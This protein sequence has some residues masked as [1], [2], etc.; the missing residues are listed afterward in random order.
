MARKIIIDT[1]PGIDDA[2]AIF[3]ALAAPE[4]E[5]LGLTTVF[6]NG[7]TQMSTANALHLLEIAGRTDIPVAHGAE[8]PMGMA[9]QGG[10][11]QVHGADAQGNLFLPAPAGKPVSMHAA[12]FIIDQVMAAPGEI[13]LV[14]LAPLTNIALAF[15]LK[16]DLPQYIREIVLMGGAAFVPGNITPAAEANIWNDPEAADIVFGADCNI[17]MIG[18]DVT[19]HLFLPGSRLEQFASLGNPRA[20]HLARILPCYRDFHVR[21]LGLDGIHVHDSSTISY[22]LRPDLFTL[23]GHPVRV[24]LTGLGRGKTWPAVGRSDVESAWAGRRP[25]QIAVKVDAD[26]ALALEWE[27]HSRTLGR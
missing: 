1:D 10:A 18:L 12:Q 4:L 22:L 21:Q 26:A 2:L 11:P 20:D 3:Y 13:T 14:P 24:E 9:F 16:P 5:I 27:H 7:S 17:V 19:E 23:E 6:G 8:R 15:L 25:I